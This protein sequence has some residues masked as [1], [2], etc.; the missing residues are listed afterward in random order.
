MEILEL[1]D[2]LDTPTGS[3][4]LIKKYNGFKISYNPDVIKNQTW[5]RGDEKEETALCIYD[6]K[7]KDYEIFLILNGDFRDEYEKIAK[8]GLKECVEFFK[9]KPNLHSSWTTLGYEKEIE[10]LK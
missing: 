10:E 4:N 2:K 1:W 5:G 7:T 8:N 6:K 9:S 3:I